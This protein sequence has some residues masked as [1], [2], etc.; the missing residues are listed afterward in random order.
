MTIH[1]EKLRL[2]FLAFVFSAGILSQSTI[3]EASEKI[4]NEAVAAFVGA[5]Q[6]AY[7]SGG[8]HGKCLAAWGAAFQ[9][10]GLGISF[11][12]NRKL[13][14]CFERELA[15]LLIA[16]GES[17]KGMEILLAHHEVW[18]LRQSK[19]TNKPSSSTKR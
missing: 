3:S 1:L 14:I 11:G 6:S 12:T 17:E 18:K 8:I 9:T 13:K 2:L 19:T 5:A 4:K 16:N 15:L 7:A 10:K